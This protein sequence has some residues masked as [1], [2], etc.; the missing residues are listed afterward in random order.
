M[1]I[2]DY[3]IRVGNEHS[4][5]LTAARFWTVYKHGLPF[6]TVS[7]TERAFHLN[8]YCGLY[9]VF[10]KSPS[11]SEIEGAIEETRHI[12]GNK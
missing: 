5:A 7:Y 1:R 12:K 11:V 8:L 3:G 6:G 10:E 4:L 2:G 9:K